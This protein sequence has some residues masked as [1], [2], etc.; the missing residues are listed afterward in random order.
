MSLAGSGRTSSKM[1]AGPASIRIVEP[2]DSG[3][4]DMIAARA[5]IRNVL[6]HEQINTYLQPIVRLRG[7]KVVGVEALSR[8]TATPVRPPNEWF[9]EAVAVGLG[10]ELEL[11]AMKSALSLLDTLPS[12]VYLSVNVSPVTVVAVAL[13]EETEGFG[14][15]SSFR[16]PRY[17][18]STS[19][20]GGPS[21]PYSQT[22]TLG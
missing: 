8:F 7:R 1:T 21:L 18:F 19:A 15:S 2:P 9:V 6:E 5:R 3:G 11:L 16:M 13:A 20:G 17:I 4:A 22:N 10:E 14:Q 12:N